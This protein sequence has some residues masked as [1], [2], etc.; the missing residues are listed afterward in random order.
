MDQEQD[1][2]QKLRVRFKEWMATDEGQTS[3]W[4]EYLMFAPD[5]FHLLCKLAI[6]DNVAA[7]D[8]AKLAGAVVYF[9]SPLDFLPE[10]LLGPLGFADDVVLAAWVLN[11]MVNRIDQDIVR[12]HWA[13]DEDVLQVIQRIIAAADQMLGSGL[14][15]KIKHKFS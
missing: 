5:L 1:F 8:K 13:G 10:V 3:K 12:S 11:N 9:L 14:W 7:A 15:N 2:Y 4:A 6:D